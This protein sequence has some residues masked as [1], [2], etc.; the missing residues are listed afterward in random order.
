MDAPPKFFF[1]LE[2]KNGQSR[3]IHAIRSDSGQELR[4]TN[5]IRRRA[6]CFYSELYSDEYEDNIELFE[7]FCGELPKVPEEVNA[8]VEGLLVAD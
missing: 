5:K 6:A 2:K 4:D 7:Y 1:G 8:E 3:V